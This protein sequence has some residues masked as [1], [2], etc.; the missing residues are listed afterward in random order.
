MTKVG[1]PYSLAER[2]LLKTTLLMRDYSCLMNLNLFIFNFIIIMRRKFTILMFGLLLAVGW[3]SD[4]SA[5]KLPQGTPW[6]QN[7]FFQRMT[8]PMMMESSNAQPIEWSSKAQLEGVDGQPSR[9]PK[10]ANYTQTAPVTHIKSWYDGKHYSWYNAQGVLQGS[11]SYTEPVTDSCQM[12]WFIR[13]LYADP[14]MP[15]IKY[16]EADNVDLAYD[17]CDFGYWLS[18]DATQDITIDMNS[19]CYITYIAL[20]EY[21]SNQPFSYYDVDDGDTPPSGWSMP[22]KSYMTRERDSNNGWYYWRMPTGYTDFYT[23]FRISSS[24]LAGHGGIRVYVNARNTSSTANRTNTYRVSWYDYNNATYY[25]GNAELHLLNSTWGGQESLVHGPVT[26]PTEN[27]YSV[28]LVKLKDDFTG[29]AEEETLTDSALYSFYNKYVSELQ[30]LTDGLRV[31]E[32]T[33]NAGTL[34]AYTGDVN[35]FFYISKGKTYQFGGSEN[36]WTTRDGN[37]ERYADRAPF[38]HMYEEFSP[39]VESGTEDHSDFY[40]KLK[41]GTTYPVVHDCQS[42]IHMLHWFAMSGDEGTNENRVN[43]LVLYIP[44]QRGVSGSRT[45]EE[46]HQ[47]TVGMY[48]IDLYADIEP[49]TTP[50]YYTVTV[51]W[52]DNLDVITHSDGIPQTYYLYEIRDKDGDGDMDTTLVTPNGTSQATWTYD[53]PVGDPSYYDI[54]YY[55][56]GTPT[57]ATNQDT[58]FAK[59]NTDDVTVPG[60]YDFLGLQW[61]RYESD[62]VTDDGENQE[63]NYYRN[64]LAPHALAVQGETGITAGNVGTTGRTLTL[65]RDD[66]KG[67]VI[68]VMD[69]ELI[70]SG[71]KAYYRIKKRPNTQVIEPGYDENGEKNNN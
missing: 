33:S 16:A 9:A 52:Y 66:N 44:D 27:G 24:V 51:D 14:A 21:G 57:E 56:I 54:S 20:Y 65:Y 4:A 3:T 23:C 55:V 7:A 15:G 58:F 36:A 49:S 25:N 59:S 37:Y 47:P 6:Y 48:M 8:K 29:R 1:E 28:V 45:Y 2:K 17:G 43:S 46:A 67:N 62:Y 41:Q 71:N 64:W 39:Y 12:Y 30:L 32:G 69:L 70:M 68:P 11:P 26:V 61:W 35:K 53:Y 40:E 5:Q 19:N 38:Y 31:Q 63:V 34:F 18:G 50:D 60:K 13:S 42:V 10:R 22:I